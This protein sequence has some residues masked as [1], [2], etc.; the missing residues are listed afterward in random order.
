MEETISLKELFQTLRKRLV[1]ILAITFIA[2]GASG[3]ISYFYLTPVYEGSAQMLVNQSKNVSQLY[4]YN[5][6][7]TNVQLI[8]TYSVIIKNPA[9]IDEVKNR[10]N[11]DV[12]SAD[13]TNQITVA[14]E[15]NSQIITVT[16]KDSD[17]KRAADIANSVS[18]VFQSEIK[19]IMKV[20]NVRILSDAKI[21]PAPVAPKKAM[22]VAIAFVVGLMA[23]VG[24]AFLLEYLDNTIKTEQDIENMLELP[25]LGAVTAFPKEK[26]KKNKADAVQVHAARGES[27]GS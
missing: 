25:V 23:G 19:N 2:T 26:Q 27:I 3:I 17:P 16:V 9:I 13:L 12:S 8:N 10:L 20:D 5:E 18:T 1:L 24:L 4:N 15:Q 14:S 22:N 11:L 6:L 21:N 7:Q